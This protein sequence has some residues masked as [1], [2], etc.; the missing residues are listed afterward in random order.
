MERE[1]FIMNKG[2]K[3]FYIIWIFFVVIA[4]FVYFLDLQVRENFEVKMR[5][6]TE[7]KTQIGDLEQETIELNEKNSNTGELNKEIEKKEQEIV[8]KEEEIKKLEET[9]STWN[10]KIAELEK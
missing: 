5:K 7:L 9:K 6:N 1:Q 2:I 10:G 4:A 8:K 3:V